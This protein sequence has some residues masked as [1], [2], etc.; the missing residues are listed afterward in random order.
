MKKAA[1]LINGLQA[2]HSLLRFAIGMAKENDFVLQAFY[3]DGLR[4]SS[5]P[6]YP[7][8]NDLSTTEPERSDEE[9]RQE[10]E[11]LKQHYLQLFK[12]ECDA[13]GVPCTV[14]SNGAMEESE[15]IELSAF[16]DLLI[17]D[18]REDVRTISLKDLLTKAHCPLVIV[19]YAFK[20]VHTSVLAY[21]GSLSSMRAIK[22]YAYLFPQWCGLPAYLIRIQENEG[23]LYQQPPLH[24]WLSV[25]FSQAET[26]VRHGNPEAELVRF[27][28]EHKNGPIIILGAY[29]RGAVSRFMHQSMADVLRDQTRYPLFI[30]H[31]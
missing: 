13:A 12:H 2:P 8:P 7:F 26:E 3:L 27:I 4:Q 21:D 19:P 1:V 23:R 9:S 17:A 16:I 24:D 22:Q 18:D 31:A 5:L 25:H 30:T 29:G 14:Y 6:D 28:E 10:A 15:V 11:R 20:E